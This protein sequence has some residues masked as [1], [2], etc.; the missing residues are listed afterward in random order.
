MCGTNVF[1]IALN[2]LKKNFLKGWRNDQTFKAFFSRCEFWTFKHLTSSFLQKYLRYLNDCRILLFILKCR[3]AAVNRCCSKKLFLIITFPI[4]TGKQLCFS[5]FLIKLHS[6][7]R[8]QR[9]FPVSIA[10]FVRIA[11]VLRNTFGDCLNEET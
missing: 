6:K 3:K 11:I 10:E 1:N 8:L 5:L 7:K 9:R 2:N 4:F